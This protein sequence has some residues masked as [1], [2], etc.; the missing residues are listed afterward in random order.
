MNASMTVALRIPAA[1]TITRSVRI[2]ER[3]SEP[4]FSGSPVFLAEELAGGV[5]E[6]ALFCSSVLI[7]VRL[8][9]F[10][11]RSPLTPSTEWGLQGGVYIKRGSADN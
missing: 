4:D 1:I 5:M 8:W 6:E 11:S 9:N 7:V 3:T 2:K 10:L